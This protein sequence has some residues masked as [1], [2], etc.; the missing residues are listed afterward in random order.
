MRLWKYLDFFC[1]G[2]VYLR[3]T[4][5]QWEKFSFSIFI[6]TAVIKCCASF[7]FFFFFFLSVW[8]SDAIY[9]PTIGRLSKHAAAD[10]ND[11]HNDSNNNNDNIDN[12]DNS[13][14]SNNMNVLLVMMIQKCKKLMFLGITS[15][16]KEL[17]S[18]ATSQIAG[19]LIAISDL[20]KYFIFGIGLLEILPSKVGYTELQGCNWSEA[21]KI[22]TVYRY[23]EYLQDNFFV[24]W[25]HH[26]KMDFLGYFYGSYVFS[27]NLPLPRKLAWCGTLRNTV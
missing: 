9:G 26:Q 3:T 15:K 22:W 8:L 4:R 24:L 7:Y 23:T 27:I 1:Y 14:N 25:L 19:N 11:D 12:N 5:N 6:R 16:Q 20:S 10:N 13:N 17:E 21:D 2:S 18:C